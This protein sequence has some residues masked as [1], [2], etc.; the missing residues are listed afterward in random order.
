MF[1]HFSR[2]IYLSLLLCF[3]ESPAALSLGDAYAT[4]AKEVI[5]IDFD[6]GAV[7]YE[8]N[9]DIPTN[10]S[11]M[12]KVMLLYMAFDR[13][14]TGRL[15]LQDSIPI[16]TKAWKTGGSRMF[17]NPNTFVTVEELIHGIATLSGNDASI[18]LAEAI[19]GTEENAAL[20]MTE[21]ARAIGTSNTTFKNAHGLAEE[22]HLTT[23]R[24]L[25]LIAQSLIKEFPEYYPYF[26]EQSYTYNKITQPNRNPL[27]S[28]PHL[29]ADGLKTGMTD[30]GGYGLI[31]SAVQ[32]GR[33]LIVVVNG[34]ASEKER[35]TVSEQLLSWGF[36][37][38]ESLTVVKAHTPLVQAHT[39]L[40]THPTVGLEVT[41]DVT[42]TLA[43]EKKK[44]IT[45]EVVYKS[46]IPT[47]LTKG[48]PVGKLVIHI[49]GQSDR[50]IPLV[51]SEPVEIVGPFSRALAAL[52]YIIWGRNEGIV[53]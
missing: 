46:P 29:N 41:E 47:P 18:A 40:G 38:F 20:E 24:D 34:L 27:L 53:K 44:G 52:R 4:K 39:W 17:L 31:G 43:K 16:S 2:F 9:A 49:P 28:V 45:M 14:K 32:N 21:K 19:G 5:L 42:V 25:A 23:V 3:Q 15:N 37:E 1:Q 7:L 26:K 8:K 11:S 6:T 51:T 35:A 48:Q 50:E 10:P 13:L 33:R 30:E 12:T 36:R 22:G